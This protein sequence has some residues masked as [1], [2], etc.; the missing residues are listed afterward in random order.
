MNRFKPD[1][2]WFVNSLEHFKQHLLNEAIRIYNDGYRHG[3]RHTYDNLSDR[4][5]FEKY[6]T[7]VDEL[8]NSQ[9]KIFL[10]L[11]DLGLVPRAED[12]PTPL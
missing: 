12:D 8:M 6:I 3:A 5:R 10:E 7:N 11:K 1:S 9:L 4:E 2:N